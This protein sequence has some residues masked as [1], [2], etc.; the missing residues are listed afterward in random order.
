MMLWQR[1]EG[2]STFHYIHHDSGY[3]DLGVASN[4][5]FLFRILFS[6]F[7]KLQDKIQN[8][9]PGF[10]ANLG[11]L[12]QLLRIPCQVHTADLTVVRMNSVSI[13]LTRAVGISSSLLG[14]DKLSFYSTYYSILL[15]STFVLSYVFLR[16]LTRFSWR[17]ELEKN[18]GKMWQTNTQKCIATLQ[19]ATSFKADSCW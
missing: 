17:S 6:S 4:P 19:I 5:G 18:E 11:V 1:K 8:G 3:H 10:K 2:H 7:P 13:Y 9:K 14:L 16:I 15:F 12:G